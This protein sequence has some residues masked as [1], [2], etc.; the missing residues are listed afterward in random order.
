MALKFPEKTDGYPAEIRFTPVNETDGIAGSPISIYLPAGVLFADKMEYENIGLGAAGLAAD[1]GQ[2]G[3]E[4]SFLDAM[5]EFAP[6]AAQELIKKAGPGA[7]GAAAQLRN[8]ISP[9]PNTR[10][11]FKQVSLRSFQYNFKMIPTSAAEAENIREIIKE[12]R[13]QM[14]PSTI[15]AGA[16]AGTSLGYNFPNRYEI[17]MFYNEVDVAPKTVPSYLEAL[18]T[19]FNPT[20]QTM[21]QEAGGRGYFAE[22]DLNLTFTESRA[23]SQDDILAGY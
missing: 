13:T 18:Q 15:A 8:K 1:R 19:S 10:A 3:F 7:L 21:F 23:L 2:E 11:L 4:G 16:N 9:N 14:Y 6:Q 17:E 12:F 22:T 20:G 5:K